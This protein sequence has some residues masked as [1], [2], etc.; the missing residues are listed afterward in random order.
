MIQTSAAASATLFGA[1]TLASAVHAMPMGGTYT[2]RVDSQT[3]QMLGPNHV[4]LEQTASGVNTGP[5]TPLDGAKVQWNETVTLKSGK[6]PVE[7]T[8][9]F[10]T[11]TGTTSSI[12]KGTVVTD[13]QGRVTAKGKYREGE[14]T[15]EFAGIKTSGT[16]N[17]VYSSKTDF[18]GEWKGQVQPPGQTSSRR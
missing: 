1:L 13:A 14:A 3:P 9:T 11:P 8:I 15:G 6:G 18:T 5:G 12:Y 17:V 7:G 16:F 10:T 4:R 2:G